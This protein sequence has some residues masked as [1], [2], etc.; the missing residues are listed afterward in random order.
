MDHLQAIGNDIARATGI[1]ADCWVAGRVA[2]GCINQSLL[3]DCGE[4]SYFVKLNRASRLDMFAAEAQGLLE[5]RQARALIV[6]EPV[7]WGADEQSAWLVM[8]HLDLTGV[9]Q[10][11]A[12][13]EGL[14]ALHRITQT[15]YG[16]QRDNTI[17]T[18]PQLNSPR[19]NWVEFWREQRLQ[20]QLQLAAQNGAGHRLDT[21]GQLLLTR[22]PALFA[23]YQPPPS[24]LHGDL[25]SGNYAYT[26]SGKP[27]IFDPAVYYG[28]REA[29]LAMT[30]LF[31]GFEP[32]FYAAYNAAWPLDDGYR[33][34]KKLYQLYH[35]LN[36]FNL[37]GGAY[38]NQAQALT[39]TLLSKSG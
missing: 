10:P 28:D 35:I 16:W 36:H 17:G 39:D 6:P 38:L 12:L 27:A 11:A 1:R 22:F 4:T 31:G 29:E 7:C 32:D 15:H 18:T 37:F 30:E 2:G 8:E 26:S 5:L 14:A 20:Y 19:T 33:L 25:W 13:G 21:T 9:P 3:L 23:S 34:R 24:L